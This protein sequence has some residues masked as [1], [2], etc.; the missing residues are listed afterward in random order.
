MESLIKWFIVIV[1]G[2]IGMVFLG[3]DIRYRKRARKEGYEIKEFFT[4][5]RIWLFVTL[6]A[7]ASVISAFLLKL[8]KL[9]FSISAI[10]ISIYLGLIAILF[11]AIDADYRRIIKKEEIR[12]TE[13]WTLGR[14]ISLVLIGGGIS[15]V[16]WDIFS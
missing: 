7:E 9:P 2:L 5:W 12:V 10:P 11:F 1:I 8:F 13:F 4:S 14:S 15:M 3:M 16:F 6:S